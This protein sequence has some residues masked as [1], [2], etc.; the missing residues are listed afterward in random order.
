VLDLVGGYGIS[1]FGHNHPELVAVAEDCLRKQKPFSAQA[2][3]RSSSARLSARVGDCTGARHVVTFGSTGADAVEV[4]IKHASLARSRLL[5]GVQARFERD[6]R[7]ARR[8]GFEQMAVPEVSAPGGQHSGGT[9]EQ[10]LTASIA[11][12]S[13][14]RRREPVFVSLEGAFHGKTAGAYAITD[15]AGV[16]EDLVVPGPKRL[17]LGRGDW[18]PEKIITAF[19]SELVTVCGVEPDGAGASAHAVP[20]VPDRGVFRRAD[21]GRGWGA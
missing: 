19:D 3:V 4:A 18:I 20:P 6:L 17:R 9:V 5:A 10:V 14:M 15:H 16:P 7:R 2:S 8:D 21:T 13:D 11:A 1:L 12:V